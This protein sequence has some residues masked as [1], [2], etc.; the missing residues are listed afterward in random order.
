MTT[1]IQKAQALRKLHVPGKPIVLYNIW[2]AGSA[3]V[4]ERTGAKA[5]ATGSWSVAAAQGYADGEE[6]PLDAAL[7]IIKRIVECTPLPVTADFEGGYASA[8]AAV[9][10]NVRSLFD[11]GI[12]GMNFEDQIVGG[13]GLH[14]INEQSIRLAAIRREADD[15]GLPIFINART[16]IFLKA[17]EGV[18]HADLVEEAIARGRA[19]HEAG[20]DGFFVPGLT[21]S[22]L[23]QTIC[24]KCKL[25]I[26]VMEMDIQRDLTKLAKLGV[27][28]IS[29]G[30]AP[31]MSLMNVLENEALAAVPMI[32]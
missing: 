23:V 25:P 19:Y 8:A 21:D 30:P 26:N 20:A 27:A 3:S 6:M 31:Y 32:E 17:E 14:S 9:S 7:S 12:A 4:V 16:D 29:F 28:R 1:Q 24:E 2:D 10:K 15:A 13:P 11:L 22:S 5:I 18:D